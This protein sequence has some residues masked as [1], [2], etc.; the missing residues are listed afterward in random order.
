MS[1]FLSFL[2]IQFFFRLATCSDFSYLRNPSNEIIE[3]QNISS[4]LVFTP[5]K[6]FFITIRQCLFMS[7][8]CDIFDNGG[9]ISINNPYT[10]FS[11]SQTSFSECKCYQ[12]QG[13]AI[14]LKTKNATF[15]SCCALHCF[16]QYGLFLQG[17][18]SEY[19]SFHMSTITQCD[20][21][22]SLFTCAALNIAGGTQ[23]VSMI[24]SSANNLN[25]FTAAGI[26]LMPKFLNMK[27]STFSNNIGES[28][29]SLNYMVS[30]TH[31]SR[32]IDSINI[33]NNTLRT[34]SPFPQAVAVFF[35]DQCKLSNAIFQQNSANYTNNFYVLYESLNVKTVIENSVFDY[36][37]SRFPMNLI[38]CTFNKTVP[39]HQIEFLNTEMCYGYVLPPNSNTT[40]E[41]MII[42]CSVFGGI[43][44]ILVVTT[45]VI[46]FRK[47]P[48]ENVHPMVSTAHLLS[49]NDSK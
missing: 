49:E 33:V 1:H 43:L 3:N 13:G 41:I 26:S 18:V 8:S 24:N 6:D 9:A 30:E 23:Y 21:G 37:Q 46:K 42:C 16:S 25:V 27:F 15:D 40:K 36:F 12:K 48:D 31:D 11:V 35:I 29:L 32:L 44:L 4:R 22:E 10:S 45:L 20:S 17:I 2:C 38:N 28:I 19:F 39:T 47:K 7:I 34:N 5:E 14:F